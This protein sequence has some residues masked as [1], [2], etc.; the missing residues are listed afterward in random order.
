MS[1]ILVMSKNKKPLKEE[2]PKPFRNK[3]PMRATRIPEVYAVVLEQIAHEEVSDLTEMVKQA[4]R[5]FLEKRNRLPR[6]T[7]PDS[8]T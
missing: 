2:P 5:E 4:I 3:V 6:P 8:S 1:T 7:A